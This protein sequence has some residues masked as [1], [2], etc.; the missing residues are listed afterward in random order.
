MADPK[1][2]GK[3]GADPRVGGGVGEEL[4]DG[5]E[6]VGEGLK[7]EAVALGYLGLEELLEAGV[8]KST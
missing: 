7:R 1:D 8:P 2:L 3:L 4:L 6:A 5:L